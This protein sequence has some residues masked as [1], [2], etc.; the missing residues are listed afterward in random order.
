MGVLERE[1]LLS[2]K[3]LREMSVNLARYYMIHVVTRH[4]EEDHQ[5]NKACTSKSPQESGD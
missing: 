3:T 5:L 4:A 2:R 1:D